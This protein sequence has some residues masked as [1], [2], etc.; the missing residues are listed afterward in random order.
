MSMAV[1]CVRHM[2]M[3]MALGQVLMRVAVLA[4]GHRLMGMG[5][6]VVAVVMSV[7]VFMRQCLV[8]VLVAMRFGQMQQHAGRHQRAAQQQAATG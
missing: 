4:G 3:R 2:C 8:R 6:V 5:M 7:R 1:V